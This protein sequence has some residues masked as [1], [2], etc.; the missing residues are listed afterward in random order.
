[1]SQQLAVDLLEVS[2]TG[3]V[4]STTI[5]SQQCILGVGL[6]LCDRA[7]RLEGLVPDGIGGTL[8]QAFYSLGPA[9]A[10]EMRVAR[11]LDGQVQFSNVVDPSE[12][13]QMIGGEGTAYVVSS[14]AW[15]AMDTST[16]TALWS[17][18]NLAL[19]PVAALVN[20]RVAMQDLSTGILHELGETGATVRSG[21]FGGRSGYQSAF[22]TWTSVEAGVLIGR[23]SLPLSESAVSF[24]FLGGLGQRNSAIRE[25]TY[26]TPE[27]AAL[28]ALDF[29]YWASAG[30]QI[31]HGGLICKRGSKYEWSEIR[32]QFVQNKVEVPDTLCQPNTI[33][34]RYHTHPGKESAVP[35]DPGDYDHADANPGIANYLRTRLFGTNETRA[36]T[37]PI[38]TL[39]WWKM[40]GNSRTARE[41]VC[42]MEGGFWVPYS[43]GVPSSSGAICAPAKP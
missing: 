11:V 20:R 27:M 19:E 10:M 24:A 5:Y 36:S 7:P 43:A 28:W 32:T 37:F 14:T 25:N 18:P 23:A 22:G 3:T 9:F 41:N 13:I 16:W 26:D 38:Q 39:S 29:I 12:R 31:E 21:T 2:P 40:P 17:N 15:R 34:A 8:V 42:R 1:M 30:A 4:T 35:S 33:A 6:D